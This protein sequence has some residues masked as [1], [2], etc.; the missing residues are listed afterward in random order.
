MPDI[1]KTIKLHLHTDAES[2]RA[3]KVMTELY[4]QACT[5]VSEYTFNNGMILN[6]NRLQSMLYQ[7]VRKKIWSQVAAC[8]I[9]I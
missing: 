6:S 9:C 2:D 3:F 5:E 4:S 8:C 1:V 7:A